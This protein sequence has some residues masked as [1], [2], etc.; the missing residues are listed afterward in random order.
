MVDGGITSDSPVAVN[1]STAESNKVD[2]DLLS[3]AATP[4]VVLIIQL[5]H[6]MIFQRNVPRGGAG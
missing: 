4:V 3:L 1:T 5:L 6:V 2:H